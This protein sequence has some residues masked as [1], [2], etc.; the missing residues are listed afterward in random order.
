MKNTSGWSPDEAMPRFKMLLDSMNINLSNPN[1]QEVWDAYKAFLKEPIL[2][3]LG[4]NG[5]AFIET[6]HREKHAALHLI[7]QFSYY[8]MS[9]PEGCEY[10]HMDQLTIMLKFEP[11]SELLNTSL[12]EWLTFCSEEELMQIE[13][14]SDFQ[15][16]IN[17]KPTSCLIEQITQ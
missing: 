7:R 1:A 6:A 11:S 12:Q 14:M 3:A 8:D 16:L 4:D 5:E 13:A 9:S 17:S 15:L 2:D 10:D